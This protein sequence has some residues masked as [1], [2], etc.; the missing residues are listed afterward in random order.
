MYTYWECQLICSVN[1]LV[2]IAF[3][4][5]ILRIC[6][7]VLGGSQTNLYKRLLLETFWTTF[8][9]ST[10]VEIQKY[11][12]MF[13]GVIYSIF[14]KILSR[15]VY[16]HGYL[17][18]KICLLKISSTIVTICKVKLSQNC[19]EACVIVN[20]MRYSQNKSEYLPQY[21]EVY[22][23]RNKVVFRYIFSQ[24]SLTIYQTCHD[25]TAILIK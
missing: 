17:K 6:P 16:F 19:T 14:P 4:V 1:I 22:L 23:F 20:F 2:V 13:F 21:L 8:L 5:V 7:Q 18:K 3:N 10:I 24:F 9:Y 15:C 11:R 25:P 12:N